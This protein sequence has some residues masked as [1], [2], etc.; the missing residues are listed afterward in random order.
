MKAV[1]KVHFVD[2]TP[3]A[4]WNVRE[5]HFDKKGNSIW[6]HIDGDGAMKIKAIKLGQLAYAEFGVR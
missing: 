2:E 5:I 1:V 6:K 4:E 3:D